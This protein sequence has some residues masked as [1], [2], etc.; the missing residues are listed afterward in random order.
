MV[1]LTVP[2]SGGEEKHDGHAPGDVVQA[3]AGHAGLPELQ[4]QPRPAH[5]QAGHNV[6]HHPLGGG[7]T[8][9]GPGHYHHHYD[10]HYHDQQ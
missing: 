1:T 10:H 6:E 8:G 3:V 4:H 2:D 7:Q 5:Q 9:A